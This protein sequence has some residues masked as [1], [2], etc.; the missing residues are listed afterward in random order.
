ME[1]KDIIERFRD[2][3]ES[4]EQGN[5]HEQMRRYDRLH[6][7]EFDR[8]YLPA[9]DPGLA[10]EYRQLVE[11]A[12]LGI[13]SLIVT[14]VAERLRVDGIKPDSG[15]PST[16]A[17]WWS[18]WQASG[19]DARQQL[20]YRDAL[21]LADG[22]VLVTPNGDMPRLTVESP[23]N[24]YVD[25]RD[26]DPL[27]VDVAVKRVGKMGWLYTDE[28][29]WHLVKNDRSV[30]GWDIAG[31]PVVH[32]MGECPLVRFPNRLD[33]AGRSQSELA[34][35]A[36]TQARINQTLFDRLLVQKF[37][38]WRILGVTGIT[39]EEDDEGNK[40]PPFRPSIDN[41]LVAEEP[42]AR[43][44]SLQ[45]SSFS[46]HQEAVESDIKHAG[47]VTQTPPHL[48]APGSISNVSAEA[49]VALEAG[50]ASK[51]RSRQLE[52]GESWERSIRLA[53]RTVG[54]QVPD[55][56]EVLWAN[57]EARSQAQVVDATMK[58]RSIGLPLRYLLERLGL[59]PAQIEAV[60]A[61]VAR[62][63]Q[64]QADAQARSFGVGG[65]SDT[66][67]EAV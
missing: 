54:E 10:N 27:L 59:T 2:V 34:E 12:E 48:L 45:S 21:A 3:Q 57:L 53:G 32:G 51:V 20:V 35:V 9:D 39:L 22:Y 26:D 56:I 65:Y 24:L 47:A 7:G 15:E 14:A 1:G 41:L 16:D 23:L 8:P 31:D 60:Q 67:T 29:I 64:V 42:D 49:L 52:W 19:L 25:L 43:F 18:W 55:G 50:L 44:T 17:R 66:P 11:R 38:S 37:A 13:C 46:E 36:A 62:E 5:R 40:V 30:L 58:L 63:A 61:E 28:A 6:R 4:A 33:S